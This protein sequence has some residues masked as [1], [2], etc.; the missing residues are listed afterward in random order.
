MRADSERSGRRAK[1]VAVALI[2][3][4]AS[5]PDSATTLFAPATAPSVH[6]AE[7]S[8]AEFLV[9]PDCGVI[10]PPPTVTRKA[11]L[12]PTMGTPFAPCTRTTTSF[13]SGVDTFA[14]CD[15]PLRGEG[16][17]RR[18]YRRGIHHHRI[19]AVHRGRDR[20]H[21]ACG[22]ERPLHV[23]FARTV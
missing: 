9:M 2:V 22:A 16:Q 8:P 21:N 14:V 3:T 19:Q 20:L 7:T 1:G 11:T 6:F 5:E 17:H 12:M 13:L 10:A 4:A 15:A 18:K 23:E